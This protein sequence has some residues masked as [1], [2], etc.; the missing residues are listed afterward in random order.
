MSMKRKIKK[1]IRSLP[2][3]NDNRYFTL[4]MCENCRSHNAYLIDGNFFNCQKC[5]LRFDGV[6]ETWVDGDGNLRVGIGEWEG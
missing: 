1:S 5:G 3:I 6:T 4:V 2:S